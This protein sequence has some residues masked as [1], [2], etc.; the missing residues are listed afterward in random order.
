M[1]QRLLEFH[2]SFLLGKLYER[3][4]NQM[5]LWSYHFSCFIYS[6]FVSDISLVWLWYMWNTL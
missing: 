4:Y 3:S 5:E 6:L 1:N 2:I